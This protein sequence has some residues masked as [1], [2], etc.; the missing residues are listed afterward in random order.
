MREPGNSAPATD[1]DPSA[2]PETLE[3]ETIRAP[4]GRTARKPRK[5][6][7]PRVPRK[8]RKPRELKKGTE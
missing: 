7:K 6:R 1:T 5:P 3:N 2:L 4:T 8:P